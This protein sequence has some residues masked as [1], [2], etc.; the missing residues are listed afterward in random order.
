MGRF[1]PRVPG[2]IPSRVSRT[3]AVAPAPGR[4]LSPTSGGR[5]RIE[6]GRGP[7]RAPSAALF[8]FLILPIFVA[9]FAGAAGAG[10]AWE[11]SLEDHS[12]RAAREA[13]AR[14]QHDRTLEIVIPL[15][16]ADNPRAQHFLGTL[17]LS[18]AGLD[19]DP[20]QAAGWFRRAARQGHAPAEYSLGYL[21]ATGAGVKRDL[22]EARRWLEAAAANGHEL[23]PGA[24]R[25]LE[26]LMPPPGDA[27]AAG[28][29]PEAASGASSASAPKPDA[30][31]SSDHAPGPGPVHRIQLLA[32]G[33]PE[34]AEQEWEALRKR[35]PHVLGSLKPALVPTEDGRLHRLW[36]GPFASRSAA[37]EA[38]EALAPA[39]CM[40]VPP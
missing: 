13:F 32:V 34:R 17:Y 33:S 7:V 26:R 11:T 30:G 2:P 20:E 18:G 4:P 10:R 9:A 36:A 8:R 16:V 39:P 24:L 37:R 3:E 31:S 38:C 15:A 14:G 28:P 23:A 6:T 12:L 25:N 5:R 29:D 1:F 35:F 21:L 27:P 19:R 40:P 22:G